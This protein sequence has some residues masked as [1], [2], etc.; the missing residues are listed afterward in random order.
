VGLLPLFADADRLRAGLAVTAVMEITGEGGGAWTIT[1]AD[2]RCTCRPGADDGADLVVT[3]DVAQ[4]FR[5]FNRIGNPVVAMLTG[6]QRVR[7]LRN[8]GRFGKLFGA[9]NLDAP[10]PHLGAAEPW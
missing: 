5:T 1:A 10:V 8:M 3:Q 6:R 7:G 4:F 9:L 2:G